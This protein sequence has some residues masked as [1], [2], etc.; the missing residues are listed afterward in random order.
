MVQPQIL[1]F[2]QFVK[3]ELHKLCQEKRTGTLFIASVD[4]RLVQFGLDQGQIVFVSC[5]NKRGPE[6]LLLL[7]EQNFKVSVTRFVEGQSPVNRLELPPTDQILQQLEG[8]VGR[9]PATG[10]PASRRTLSDKAKTVLEQE[11][12]EFIGPMAAIIC[13]E[14]WNSVGELEAAL[15][16]LS[17]ELPD[18]GQVARF[19]QNV[20]K[21]LA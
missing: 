20:L 16:V 6:A 15:E 3:G 21:R 12:V 11:L 2:A 8:G 18:P 14:T 17:R 13:E 5:Q 1:Y 19:R 10:D 9:L 7:Q 4:N